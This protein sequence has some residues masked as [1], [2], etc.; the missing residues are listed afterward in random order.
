MFA[1][2]IFY[3]NGGGVLQRR[4]VCLWWLEDKYLGSKSWDHLMGSIISLKW[5]NTPPSPLLPSFPSPLEA[6]SIDVIYCAYIN[7]YETTWPYGNNDVLKWVFIATRR[8]QVGLYLKK[9][10]AAISTRKWGRGIYLARLNERTMS[11]VE[12]TSKRGGAE[13]TKKLKQ[14]KV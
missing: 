2:Q 8:S 1:Q 7:E 10:L 12:S 14:S 13:C 11:K 3:A 9:I 5:W 4:I 6:W